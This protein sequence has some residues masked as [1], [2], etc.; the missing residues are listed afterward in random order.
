MRVYV[1]GSRELSCMHLPSLFYVVVEPEIVDSPRKNIWIHK[2]MLRTDYWSSERANW[3]KVDGF[4][5]FLHLSVGIIVIPICIVMELRE[6]PRLI[7]FSSFTLYRLI[8]IAI[9]IPY[10]IDQRSAFE[11]YI[12]LYT[13]LLQI[14]E[15]KIS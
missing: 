6:Y 7:C 8:N 2:L 9:Q 11:T 4:N 15:I 5:T 3:D 10:K 12:N 14:K 1:K 13:N